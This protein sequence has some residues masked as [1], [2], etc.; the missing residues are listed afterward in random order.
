[1][2]KTILLILANVAC[3]SAGNILMKAGVKRADGVDLTSV[4]SIVHKI[5]LNPVLIVSVLCYVASL[6]FYIFM[7][8]RLNLNIAYPI[9]LSSNLV[10]V[11]LG[12]SLLLQ[13]SISFTQISGMIIIMFGI[14]V[15][16]R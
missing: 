13:E 15:L 7:L 9:A 3:N 1:M 16:T 5:V 8:K 2:I 14:F 6:V 4:S 10:V 12:S 11:T